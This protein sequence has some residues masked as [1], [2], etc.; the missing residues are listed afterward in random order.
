MSLYMKLL[1]SFE[2]MIPAYTAALACSRKE[3]AHFC[4]NNYHNTHVSMHVP[5]VIMRCTCI[6][7]KNMK[8]RTSH[9]D[10]DS[11]TYLQTDREDKTYYKIRRDK[12][13]QDKTR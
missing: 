4:N 7:T 1:P 3:N 6:H 10:S 12:I 2:Y 13:R 9:R 11:K 8:K 5:A